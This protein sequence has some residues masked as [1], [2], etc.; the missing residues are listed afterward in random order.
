MRPAGLV[1]L[2]LALIHGEARS[3]ACT[4]T[5]PS[6]LVLLYDGAGISAWMDRDPSAETAARTIAAALVDAAI[7][8]RTSPR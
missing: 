4:V 7:P 8:A 1:S 6:R 2:R 5:G 3:A